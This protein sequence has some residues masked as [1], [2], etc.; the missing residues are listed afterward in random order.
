MLIHVKKAQST[1]PHKAREFRSLHRMIGKIP[2][3]GRGFK[4]LVSYLLNGALSTERPPFLE[5]RVLWIETHNLLTRDPKQAVRIMRA[6]A[7]KS[8]RCKSPVYHF[9]ISW[10]PEE[11]PS[12]DL[13]RRIVAD[14]CA[15]LELAEHQRIVIAHQDT[16]HA[17]VHVVINRVHPDTGKAWNR[18]QD[19]VRLEQSLARQATQHGLIFVPG[20]HNTDQLQDQPRKARD[21]EYQQ[22]R[23]K[24]KP[25]PSMVWPR[26]RIAAERTHIAALF[27]AA[28][29]WDQL[30]TALADHGL[31]LHR[32][33][34]GHVLRDHAGEMKLSQISKTIRIAAL[35][36]RFKAPW[37]ATNPASAPQTKPIARKPSTR[38]EQKPAPQQGKTP[39]HNPI[40]KHP[41]VIAPAAAVTPQSQVDRPTNVKQHTFIET[42]HHVSSP[43]AT[44]KKRKRNKGPKL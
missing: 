38:N 2:K 33:G 8:R 29:S 42:H 25:T 34:Q 17:H 18:Q 10:T 32:K 28:T 3:A 35:E 7:N 36:N 27:E 4:G 9:V 20:R 22:S 41:Q 12:E 26:S 1:R 13:K 19:W 43:P 24:G 30:S 39:A 40:P 44:A 6:T 31:T 5:D 15:D 11:N 16:R 37:R 23:R 21:P 14:T